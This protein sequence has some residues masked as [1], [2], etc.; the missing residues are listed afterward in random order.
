MLTVQ[1]LPDAPALEIP[2]VIEAAGP[3]AIDQYVAADPAARTAQ[4]AAFEAPAT[5]PQAADAAPPSTRGRK[6][7]AS[8]E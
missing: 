5:P 7:T 6:S 8:T 1:L 3:A 4:V 2:R